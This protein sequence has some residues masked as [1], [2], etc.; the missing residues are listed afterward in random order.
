MDFSI[1]VIDT[2]S[3]IPSARDSWTAVSRVMDKHS[4]HHA[5]CGCGTRL[6]SHSLIFTLAS[7]FF[8]EKSLNAEERECGMKLEN[9]CQT[10][11][12]KREPLRK[13]RGRLQIL[14]HDS[15]NLARH[16][17]ALAVFLTALMVATAFGIMGTAAG[18]LRCVA[19]A[20]YAKG[21][22]VAPSESTSNMI[23]S[24]PHAGRNGIQEQSG[25]KFQ[26]TLRNTSEPELVNCPYVQWVRFWNGNTTYFSNKLAVLSRLDP[27]TSQWKPIQYNTTGMDGYVAFH[28][29]KETKPGTYVYKISCHGCDTYP[30]K[31][32]VTY[33]VIFVHGWIGS[34]TDIL[35]PW[36]NM[37]QALDDAGFVRGTHYF[38]LNYDSK[39]DPRVAA[40][41]LQKFIQERKAFFHDQ[42]QYDDCKFTIV[43]H[44]MGALVTRWYMERE[45][46]AENVTQWIGIA[47]TNH[48]VAVADLP[49]DILLSIF[50]PFIGKKAVEQ[51][52]TDS[53]TVRRLEAQSLAPGVTYR[54]IV[55][56][57]TNNVKGF[58]YDMFGLPGIDKYYSLPSV[59]GTT[60]ARPP[61][62]H[63]HGCYY[64]TLRGD[65]LVANVQSWIDSADFQSFTGLSH[66]GLNHNRTVINYVL[67]CIENPDTRGQKVGLDTFLYPNDPVASQSPIPS[68]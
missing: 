5:A 53:D 44:S 18:A 43:C 3:S 20:G 34:S 42:Y 48:G 58:G 10:S 50:N 24:A 68:I 2:M 13:V 31:V 19:N 55:G 39:D 41:D 6:L 64:R 46:G 14:R 59:H 63:G 21:A 65:G 4:L 49:P 62:C 25:T 67:R 7:Q 12:N 36:T 9:G 61:G 33:P 32:V 28:G 27:A 47:P 60:W 38:V 57:N 16:K 15:S 56:N 22:V 40:N 54:V 45:G 52:R 37:T 66:F 26:Y 30:L 29:L 8:N 35:Y 17:R 51:Q 11:S 23:T 1:G